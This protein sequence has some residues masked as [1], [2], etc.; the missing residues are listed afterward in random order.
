MTKV[1]QE[2]TTTKLGIIAAPGWFDPTQREFDSICPSSVESTQTIMPPVGFDYSFDQIEELEPHLI[3]AS[4]LLAQSGCE[5]IAQV[6]P[7]FAYFH[8]DTPQGA[9]DLQQS[10]TAENDVPVILNGVAVLDALDAIGGKKIALA[11][12]YYDPAWKARFLK[13]LAPLN[14]SIES[15][16]TFVE[17]EIFESQEDVDARHYHF[18]EAEIKQSILQTRAAAPNADVLLVGGAGVRFINII[19]ELEAELG[20]PLISADVS[21][22]WSVFRALGIRPLNKNLGTL[23]NM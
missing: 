20:I 4:T 19:D 8:D 17:Q 1:Q 12:P 23:L 5:L 11:C 10:L 15:C 16:Q 21:L 3:H 6:G 9:R 14:Y 18:S 13:F 7:A 2:G 22:Y